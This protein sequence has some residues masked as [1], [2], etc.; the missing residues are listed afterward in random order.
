MD[1]IKDYREV[2]QKRWIK[3]TKISILCHYTSFLGNTYV[4]PCPHTQI[5]TPSLVTHI[6]SKAPSNSFIHHS[7]NARSLISVCKKEVISLQQRIKKIFSTIPSRLQESVTIFFFIFIVDHSFSYI[8]F[9][10]NKLQTQ[11]NDSY[12]LI[13]TFCLPFIT[14]RNCFVQ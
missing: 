6:P 11:T 14:I 3:Y 13:S 12:Y 4:F 10:T 1:T 7:L 5:R 9:T 8:L 2:F